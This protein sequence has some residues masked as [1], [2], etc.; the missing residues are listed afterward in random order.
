MVA[1]PEVP[2]PPA[3]RRLIVNADDFGLNTATNQAVIRAHREGILTTASLMVNEPGF[4]EAVEMAREHP[5]LGVGLHLTLLGGHSS[6]SPDQIPGLVNAS[7]EFLNHPVLT[8]LRF[9]FRSSLRSQLRSEIHAQFKKFQ[10]TGLHLD[11]INGHLHLHLHPTV[12]CIL[13]EDAARLGIQR[14]R[15]T[16]DPFRL[17]LRVASGRL[18]YRASHAIIFGL[19][20]RRAKPVLDRLGI[21]YT[22]QVFGLLQNALVDVPYLKAL[23]PSL[24][25][26]DSELYSHPS[27]DDFKNEL[28]AL[29]NPRV[30]EQIDR[31]G[32]QLIRYQDL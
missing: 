7:G 12:F 21:R 29:I 24:P 25:P 22:R 18:V 1:E 20:S 3:P 23:L 17:N 32:I 30:R 11:H 26:G 31:L 19:L 8:G 15:L 16:R 4:E 10:A 2:G 5:R 28:N 27:V 13:T 14:M 6:L 9:F